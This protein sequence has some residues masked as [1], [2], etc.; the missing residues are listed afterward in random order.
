[1]SN[2]EQ[3]ISRRQRRQ[4]SWQGTQRFPSILKTGGSNQH[5][6]RYLSGAGTKWGRDGVE[7]KIS[8]ARAAKRLL[9]ARAQ[10]YV[11]TRRGLI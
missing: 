3:P 9:F 6:A 10:G 2:S 11:I 5:E 1:M 7:V 8:R 4:Y